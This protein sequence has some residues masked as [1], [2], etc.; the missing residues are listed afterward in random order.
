VT[1]SPHLG[2]YCG[3]IEQV[4]LHFHREKMAFFTACKLDVPSL[5][6]TDTAATDTG[7]DV[8]EDADNTT[9]ADL[10]DENTETES[11]CA[12][13]SCNTPT[14]EI[15]EREVRIRPPIQEKGR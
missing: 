5:V 12:A 13:T 7:S 9:T 2:D 10:S 14:S 1:L 15:V 11:V 3:K 4:T 8:T 6:D